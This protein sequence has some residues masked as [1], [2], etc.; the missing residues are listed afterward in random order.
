MK[1][2]RMVRRLFISAAGFALV[3]GSLALTG[4]VSASAA[5]QGAAHPAASHSFTPG[6]LF[7]QAPGTRATMVDGRRIVYSSNW[8]GYAVIGST[9]TT[10][11]ANWTQNAIDCTSNDGSTDMSPWVGIDGYNTSTVEQTGSSGDCNGATPDYYAWYEMYPRN[12]QIINKTVEPGDHFTATVTHTTGTDYTLKLEDITQ[13][14]T[15]SVTKSISAKDASAEAVMEMAANHLTKWTGT[16]PF[17]DFTV[18]GQPIG[19]YTG[20]PYTIEQMEIEDGSTVCDTTSALSGNEN[21][22]ET[23]DNA[24]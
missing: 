18:D 2:H 14:W 13:G 5:H 6:G 20:S 12:V 17:T 4:P 15:N 3:A 9:F 10:A 21:F 24:C 19:S 11:T 7:R 1:E 16:D 23:W 8:S 22:T